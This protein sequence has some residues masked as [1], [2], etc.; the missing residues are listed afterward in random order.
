MLRSVENK[1]A[2]NSYQGSVER[3]LQQKGL[4]GSRNYLASRKFLDRSSSC[5][6]AI[7]NVIKRS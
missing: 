4:D 3:C 1:N 6:E 7:E 5:Q 2:R